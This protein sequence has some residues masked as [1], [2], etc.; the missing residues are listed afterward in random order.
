MVFLVGLF[1][2]SP[3]CLLFPL[4]KGGGRGLGWGRGK[5]RLAFRGAILPTRGPALR[6]PGDHALSLPGEEGDEGV[7]SAAG[8]GVPVRSRARPGTGRAP[9]SC[10][11]GRG[12]KARGVKARGLGRPAWRALGSPAPAMA[13][14]GTRGSCCEGARASGPWA[15]GPSSRPLRSKV[16]FGPGGPGALE[17]ALGPARGA[18]RGGP[19]RPVPRH[20]PARPPPPPTVL[21]HPL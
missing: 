19:A 14:R 11:V 12:V 9:A 13:G 3:C 5:G 18:V 16:G 2:F 8:A 6:I 4:A 1:Q 17:A 15:F 10:R 21:L 20:P 7:R